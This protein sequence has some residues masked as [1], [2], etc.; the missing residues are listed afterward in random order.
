MS[1]SRRASVGAVMSAVLAAALMLVTPSAASAES[2][3]G[4][5]V[6]PLG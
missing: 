3:G 5:R 4:T 6:L 2:N 1:L